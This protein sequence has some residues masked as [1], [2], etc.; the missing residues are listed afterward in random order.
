MKDRWRLEGKKAVVTGATKG[1]GRA[2]AE[3]FLALGAEVL[4]LSR[5]RSEID[6]LVEEWRLEGHHV[7]GLTADV[8]LPE[9]REHVMKTIW[10]LW[11]KLDILVNNVGTN[12]RKPTVDYT[13]AVVD[14]IL[15]TNLISTFELCRLCYPLL[16]AAQAASIVNISSVAGMK[17]V[18]SGPPYAMTKAAINQLTQNLAVEWALAGIRVNAVAPWYIRTPL[19]EQVLKNQA[20]LDAVLDQTPL[21]RIG[22]PEEVAALVAFLCMPAASYITGQ[23]IAVDGGFTVYGF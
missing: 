3:E 23:V 21:K 8:S 14:S 13:P 20:Y 15:Q 18:R 16:Q 17:H 4:I 10:A 1:I 22:E 6:A 2:I 12:I 7:Y 19:A 9:D 11:N 5:H